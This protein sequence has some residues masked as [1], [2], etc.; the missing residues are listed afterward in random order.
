VSAFLELHLADGSIR[1]LHPDR[2]YGKPSPGEMQLLHGI[3]GPV[4][5]VGCGP[6]RL[7][8]GLGRLGVVA[9]GIDPAPGAVQACRRRGA[10][11]LQRSVFQRL[12]AEARW[13][14]VLLADGN[15]GIGGDPVRL[16][17]RCR[18][19]TDA[20]GHV[21]VELAP[22]GTGV[23]R[24]RARLECGQTVG[25]WFDWAEVGVDAIEEVA[26]AAGLAPINYQQMVGE[27]RW[28]ATLVA[29]Q[30]AET[31]VGATDAVA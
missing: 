4:L 26:R 1:P 19:L 25:P 10:P 28:F 3:A 6:G 16:L 20:E 5:D 21:L 7:V 24:H 8:V 9:L 29:A 27:R 12:P 13:R 14:T 11:V 31:A 2:W 23:H 17:A 18:G 30:S 22:P 15:I